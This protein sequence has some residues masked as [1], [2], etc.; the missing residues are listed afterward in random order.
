MDISHTR[1]VPAP[2]E[3]VWEALNDPEALRACIPGCESFVRE[4]DGTW[5]ATVATKIG[6][7]SARFAGRVELADV[8]APNGYTLKFN[9]QGGAAGFASGSAKVT[10][11]PAV[12]GTTLSYTAS[13][14][15]GGKLAQIGSRLVDGAAAKLADDFFARLSERVAPTAGAD[16]A[17][18]AP[19]PLL[20]ETPVSGTWVRYAAIAAIVALILWLATTGGVRF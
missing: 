12:G 3:T 11:A 19:A 13:A 2:R 20:P 5:S 18:P 10:L 14:Q 4:A 6:P 8:D 1:F 7:V 16:L 17:T 15:I 9:G